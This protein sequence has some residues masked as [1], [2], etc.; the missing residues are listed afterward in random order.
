MKLPN[1]SSPLKLFSPAPAQPAFGVAGAG[2]SMMFASGGGGGDYDPDDFDQFDD[3]DEQQAPPARRPRATRS[4]QSGGGRDT[5]GGRP[6][7]AQFQPEERFWTD[8]LRIAL[9]V[10][11][12]LLLIGLL[13]F[14][15]DRLISDEPGP[16]EPVP[17]ETLGQ[18]TTSTPTAPVSTQ[19]A[20]ITTPPPSTQTNTAGGETAVTPPAETTGGDN[21]TNTEPEATE[22]PA[23]NTESGATFS[24]G[25]A[26]VVT[27]PLN[28]RPNPSTDG[29]P[30]AELAAGD[31]LTI[32]GGPETGE[33]YTW[34][35]VLTSDGST[36]GWVVEDF[37]EPAG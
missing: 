35:E 9:P 3:V 11:G 34:W 28:L 8:Y 7:T 18:V 15:A 25:E 23:D 31:E 17:S 4:S 20:V 30:V 22:P 24:D 19:P 16:S 2:G 13:W 21:Q 6:R 37:I 12:L 26:V 14:W 29:E 36:T 33:G 10:V 1:I 32:T 27:E 5:T